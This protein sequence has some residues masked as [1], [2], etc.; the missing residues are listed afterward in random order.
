ML[1]QGP[2]RSLRTLLQ[3]LSDA[4]EGS[5]FSRK[6]EVNT[7]TALAGVLRPFDS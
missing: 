5:E 7:V 4:A 6:K 3:L 1:A 2:S